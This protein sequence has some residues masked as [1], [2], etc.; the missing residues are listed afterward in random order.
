MS[1]PAKKTAAKKKPAKKN[2]PAKKPKTSADKAYTVVRATGGEISGQTEPD[3]VYASR[4]AAQ[5]D[6]DARNAELRQLLNPF[7]EASAGYVLSGGE[8]ELKQLVARLKLPPP[9]SR[10]NYGREYTDWSEW[11]DAHYFD[12]TDAQR[13]AIWDALTKF[14]WYKVR[15]TTL[16][17]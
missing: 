8:T 11:W 2:P 16:E 7:A 4:S 17:G 10:K 14:N 12:M 3:R 15:E 9:K 6:A 1:R 5:A 13:D